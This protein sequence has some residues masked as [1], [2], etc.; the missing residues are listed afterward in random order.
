MFITTYVLQQVQLRLQHRIKLHLGAD[1]IIFQY[2]P[3]CQCSFTGLH[4]R[5]HSTSVQGVGKVA[6]SF[7]L[8]RLLLYCM[9]V[10][11]MATET[12]TVV[13]F[14]R[15]WFTLGKVFSSIKAISYIWDK[16]GN[17]SI[18]IGSWSLSYSL[19][20][21]PGSHWEKTMRSKTKRMWVE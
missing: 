9:S 8:D 19:W 16:W 3:W 1:K 20:S 10:T 14:R 21:W 2:C 4:L 12:L 7:G 6:E 18:Y 5:L 15:G 11:E 17:F 13:S